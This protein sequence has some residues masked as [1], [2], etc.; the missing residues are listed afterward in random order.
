MSWRQT[1]M[2][3]LAHGFCLNPYEKIRNKMTELPEM[4]RY[5][6]KVDVF[7]YVIARYRRFFKKTCNFTA[8]TGK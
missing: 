8:K 6:A 2:D 3:T 7:I 5:W 1:G 4:R